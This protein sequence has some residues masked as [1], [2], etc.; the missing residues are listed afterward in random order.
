MGSIPVRVV[1][2]QRAPE[3]RAIQ[4]KASSAM[5]PAGPGASPRSHPQLRHFPRGPTRSSSLCSACSYHR[6]LATDLVSSLHAH[7]E[8]AL[9]RC[10]FVHKHSAYA[11]KLHLPSGR[12]GGCV[13]NCPGVSDRLLPPDSLIQSSRPNR[14]TCLPVLAGQRHIYEL[15]SRRSDQVGRHSEQ[16]RLRTRARPSLH[17]IL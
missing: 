16:T 13:A 1:E 14:V 4:H 17:P 8:Q 6:P 7:K 5:V 12:P 15:L 3:R 9:A 2:H 10:G 11:R